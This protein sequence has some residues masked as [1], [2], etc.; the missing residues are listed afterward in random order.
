MEAQEKRGQSVLIHSAS[1]GVGTSCIQL[2][3]YM[4]AE[5]YVTVGTEEKRKFLRD[6]YGIPDDRMFSSRNTKFA[7]EILQ[8]TNGRG[9][10]VIMNSLI[11]DMLDESRRICADG[12]TL[13]EI[14]K[15]D[16]V[17]LS[18]SWWSAT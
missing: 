16:I 18:V 17:D 1:G 11:G 12:G 9:V 4:E 3:K 5:I 7:K 15:K 6:N 13:V 8:A 10:D 2:A 14:G